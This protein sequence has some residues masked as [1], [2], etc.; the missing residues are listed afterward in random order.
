M[1]AL[2]RAMAGE[3]SRGV[4][5][6]VLAGQQ[7][8]A[9]LGFKQGGM[10]GYGLRRM[11]VSSDRQPKQSLAFGERKSIT[12]DRVIVVPGPEEEVQVVRDIYQMLVSDGL[13]IHAVARE[14]NRRGLKYQNGARWTHHTVAEVLTNP[15][16][17]GF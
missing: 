5:V 2:K 1:K 11:L 7:R 16:Y 6:K 9:R 13:S 17:A 14:L 8:L 10:P 12:T 3:Y 15:K 4:G